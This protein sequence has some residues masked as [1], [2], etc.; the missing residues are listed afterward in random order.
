MILIAETN[1]YGSFEAIVED[2]GRSVYLYL[3]SAREGGPMKAAWVANR[4]VA[5]DDE[6]LA[7]L[8]EG[9]AP[10]M[11]AAG[12]RNPHGELG[13]FAEHLTLVWFEEGDGVALLEKGRP[14]AVLPSW[15]GTGGFHGYSIFA[16]GEQR[17]AWD[18]NPALGAFNPRIAAAIQYWEWREDPDSWREI[19]ARG[20]KHLESLFGPHQRYWSA[21]GGGFPPRAVVLFPHRAVPN[22]TILATLGMSAQ[23]LPGVETA[24]EDPRPHSRIELVAAT[25]GPPERM[26]ALLSGVMPFPWAEASWL[27]DLHTYSFAGPSPLPGESAVLLMRRPPPEVIHVPEGIRAIPPP[28]FGGQVDA[29]GEPVSYLYLLPISEPERQFAEKEGSEALARHLEE[30]QR[31]WVWG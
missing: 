19:Q 3:Q 27:G 8:E 18:L 15:S 13:L 24:F 5:P 9:V 14:V 17:L 6:D 4:I 11:P 25:T 29:S 16:R 26:A 21:D 22:L 30:S 12:A 28:N 20:L 1:P 2:D 10:L 31:G 23:P 7:A